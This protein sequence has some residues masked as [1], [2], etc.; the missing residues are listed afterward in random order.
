MW[1]AQFY[2]LNCNL[3]SFYQL[4]FDLVVHYTDTN[5]SSMHYL[6]DSNWKLRQNNR[7]RD[8]YRL[9][10]F[11]HKLIMTITEYNRQ[12]GWKE[13][14]SNWTL[15]RQTILEWKWHQGHFV[16]CLCLFKQRPQFFALFHQ[17]SLYI[18]ATIYIAHDCAYVVSIVFETLAKSWLIK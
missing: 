16:W 4:H 13:L 18:F 11:W 8:D 14:T 6:K 10:V 12:L 2:F 15:K 7:I 3:G 17:V 5:N 1:I 9:V